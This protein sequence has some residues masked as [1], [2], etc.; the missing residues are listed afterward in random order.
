MDWT[1]LWVW[2]KNP[3]IQKTLGLFGAVFAAVV[4]AC[5]ALYKHFRT[6]LAIPGVSE[7]TFQEVS[8][9]YG[10]TKAA[11]KNFFKILEREQVP[12]EDLDSTL[13]TFAE[14][15]KAIAEELTRVTSDDPEVTALKVPARKALEQGEL[16]RVALLTPIPLASGFHTG[17]SS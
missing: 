10:V 8:E 14:N 12:P 17:G 3:E 2:L 16:D 1:A 5:W 4:T 13:R 11:L 9:N 7:Q 6:P 15:Y